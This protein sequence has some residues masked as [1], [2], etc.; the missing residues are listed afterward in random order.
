MSPPLGGG[1]GPLGAARG[2]ANFLSISLL[3][4]S[5]LS[6]FIGGLSSLGRSCLALSWTAVGEA[7]F[8]TAVRRDEKSL[9]CLHSCRK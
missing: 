1:G 2:V 8:S 3:G 4:L 9:V 7:I 6:G 5:L